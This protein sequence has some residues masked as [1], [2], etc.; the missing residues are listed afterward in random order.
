MI[1][2]IFLDLDNT[3]LDFKRGEEIALKNALRKMGIEIDERI[4]ERYLE[5]NLSLWR[6]LERGEVTRDEVLYGRFERLFSEIGADLSPYETQAIYQDMLG[7]EHD[8]MP[9]ARKLLDDLFNSGKYRLYIATNG[10]PEVQYPRI[11]DSGIGEY[12]ERVFISYEIGFPKPKREFFEG[13]FA[14]IEG[15]N[16]QEAIIVGDSLTSDIMGGI[17]A[18]IHTCH[19]NVWG[20]KYD[21]ITP[22]YRINNLSE[23][24]PLLESI[25]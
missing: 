23:L 4:A 25:E 1:K 10:I 12:I 21:S 15:F 5:I 19:Y 17:N 22:E 13:C 8:F 9:G 11:S 7:R 2:Y 14:E 24:I 6:A 16:H 20:D 3:L 18:G